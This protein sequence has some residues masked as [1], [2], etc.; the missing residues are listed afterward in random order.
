MFGAI[1]LFRELRVRRRDVLLLVQRQG[2]EENLLHHKEFEDLLGV[3]RSAA[4]CRKVV[5]VLR[6]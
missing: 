2:V 3:I 6:R 5:G 1:L 4:A